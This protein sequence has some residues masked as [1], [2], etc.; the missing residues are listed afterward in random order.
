MLKKIALLTDKLADKFKDKH[1]SLVCA[2]SCT[3]GGITYFIANNPNSSPILERG[4]VVYSPK[5]KQDLLEVKLITLERYGAVSKETVIEM[6]EGA[7]KNSKAHIS[8]ATTGIAGNDTS[9]Q[10]QK[11]MVWIACAGIDM[12]TKTQFK[13]I[14]GRRNTFSKKCVLEALAFL[15]QYVD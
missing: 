11:G 15:I 2:E 10:Q 5:A 12:K 8:L 9:E 7:L 1:L 13:E 3:A 6:A 14:S 4:Y